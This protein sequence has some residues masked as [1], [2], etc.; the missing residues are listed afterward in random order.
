VRVCDPATKQQAIVNIQ[1]NIVTYPTYRDKFML[2]RLCD[3]RLELSHCRSGFSSSW[4]FSYRCIH[5][6]APTYLA[7]ELLQ[8][9]DRG[10]RTLLRSALTT[11]LPVRRTRLSTVSDRAFHV[12]AARTWNDLPR[13]VRSASSLPVFRS[14]LKMHLFRHFFRHFCSVSAK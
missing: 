11:S 13:H 8:R 3:F 5:G 9:A 4:P 2:R 7:D 14:R 10:I 1:L 12:S 6:T